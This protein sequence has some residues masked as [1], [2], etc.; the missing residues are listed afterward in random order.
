MTHK[1][2]N[3]KISIVIPVYN[4]VL[5]LRNCI[6]SILQQDFQ[7]FEILL[8]N[9]GSTDNSGEMCDNIALNDRRIKALHQKNGGVTSAR[10][11]GVENACGEYICFVDA[12]DTLP[13]NALKLLYNRANE[14]DLDILVTA[15]NKIYNN[16]IVIAS[17]YPEGILSP[18]E[19]ITSTVSGLCASGPHGRLFKRKIFKPDVLDL[20]REI[21]VNEDLIMNIRLGIYAQKIEIFNDIITYNYF[22]HD[23]TART[24]KITFDTFLKIVGECERVMKIAS[25]DIEKS[26]KA[27]INKKISLLTSIIHSDKEKNK[28]IIFNI[29]NEGKKTSGLTLIKKEKLY[30]HL[31]PQYKPIISIFYKVR[32]KLSEYHKKFNVYDVH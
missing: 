18:S 5:Y 1:N 25:T 26:K 6:N 31:Y 19:F 7:L 10:R 23:F 9:D 11:L 4:K 12:D 21:I 29:L 17:S 14:K 15:K 28:D 30:T 22:L 27:L 16:R 24:T 32:R 3:P 13:E 20:T 2:L 8:V